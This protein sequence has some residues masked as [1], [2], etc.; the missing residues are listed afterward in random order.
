MR[1]EVGLDPLDA[2]GAVDPDPRRGTADVPLEVPGERVGTPVQRGERAAAAV[3]L[4][5]VSLR[6]A[7]RGTASPLSRPRTSVD[8]TPATSTV[9]IRLNTSL[10]H[11]LLEVRRHVT[12]LLTGHD[13]TL[14]ELVRV[15]RDAEPVEVDPAALAMVRRARQVVE[16]SLARGDEVYGLTTGVGAAKR[17]RIEPGGIGEFNRLIVSG[18]AIGQGPDVTPE[19]VRGTL[20]RLVNGFVSGSA[21]V[22]PELVKRLVDALNRQQH[23]RVRAIGSIGQ[24]DLV[25]LGELAAGLLSDFE[26]APK[27]G[28]ALLSSNAFSTSI[29]ALAVADYTR[30]V[31]SA[32]AAAAF[33]LEAFAANLTILHPAVGRSR[34]FA[35]LMSTLDRLRAILDGSW[36]WD[37]GAARNLQ[38][39][40]TFRCIPQVHGNV[41][42]TLAFAHQQLTVELN[43]SQENPLVLADED[44]L[45]SVGNFD[46]LPL[47][48]CLDYLR[49]A[50]A[51]LLTSAY[52]R[53][54]KLLQ[55]PTSGL[56]QNLATHAGVDLALSEFGVVGQALTA[57]A[58]LLAGPV[59]FE[60]T[61]TSRDQG[62]T[63]R[64][65]MAPLGARRVAEMVELGERLLAIE[66]V[67]AAQAIDLRRTPRLGQGT[68]RL[69]DLVR[70]QVAPTGDGERP[71][72]DLEGVRELVRSGALSELSD[73]EPARL[74]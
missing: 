8:H 53:F 11:D 47:A 26:L 48:A 36:L 12:I 10:A 21:G 60:L 39:P 56:P 13:L 1:R 34:P 63:D 72:S 30:L 6:A 19:I 71:P 9:Y 62:I 51:P 7:R 67:V 15:A 64:M 42:D 3:P 16:R 24:A 32:D 2:I 23:P 52:E 44:R 46:V 29:A 22:R 68:Q 61:G 38:D 57:E 69:H 58:R 54:E 18:S 33:D 66:L 25:P 28:L 49:I 40:L 73:A 45:I 50:L 31:D 59:S 4:D 5:G 70:A 55:A 17:F 14:A 20:L 35:G 27:E 37:P 41:R 74:R 65:T 43:A